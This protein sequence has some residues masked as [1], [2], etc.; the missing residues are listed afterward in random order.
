MRGAKVGEGNFGERIE[1]IILPLVTSTN[2]SESPP[3]APIDGALYSRSLAFVLERTDAANARRRER[4]R[5]R[6]PWSSP[7]ASAVNG[8][9]QQHLGAEAAGERHLGDRDEEAAVRDVVDRR[10]HALVDQ[11]ANEFATT[12]S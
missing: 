11:I 5:D 8:C 4:S 7:N 9:P 6:A 2:F 3:T 12:S 1:A 10:D